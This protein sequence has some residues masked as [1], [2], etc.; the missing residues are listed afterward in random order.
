MHKT[1]SQIAHSLRALQ[2]AQKL[3]L[4]RSVRIAAGPDACEPAQ[5]QRDIEYLGSTVPCLK[6][7]EIFGS[8]RICP[9]NEGLVPKWT[10]TVG[11]RVRPW[12]TL[13]A[14]PDTARFVPRQAAADGVGC[15]G[16][17]GPV[18]RAARGIVLMLFVV[19]CE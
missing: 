13:R 11:R 10:V 7:E 14:T 1:P 9:L 3:G 8:R 16:R 15:A 19:V 4:L 6:I 2:K 5:S 18:F 12:A 17:A